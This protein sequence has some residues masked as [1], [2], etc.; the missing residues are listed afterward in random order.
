MTKIY[1]LYKEISDQYGTSELYRACKRRMIAEYHQKNIKDR[2]S[3]I[4]EVELEE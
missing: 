1:L 2:R 4:K 3:Y